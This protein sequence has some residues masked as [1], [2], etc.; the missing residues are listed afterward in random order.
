MQKL[1]AVM[2]VQSIELS[3]EKSKLGGSRG[4]VIVQSQRDVR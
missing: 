2:T 4:A 1:Y 3:A